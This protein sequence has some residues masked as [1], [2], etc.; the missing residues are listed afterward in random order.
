MPPYPPLLFQT[1][2]E[3]GVSAY[4]FILLE[5]NKSRI[6]F[7]QYGFLRGICK[8]CFSKMYIKCINNVFSRY[9]L[10][11]FSGRGRGGPIQRAT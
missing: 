6:D 2:F 9:L 3:K 4:I 1:S 8:R 10:F 11:A 5:I 7:F